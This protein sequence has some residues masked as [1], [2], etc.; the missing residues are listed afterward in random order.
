MRAAAATALALAASGAAALPATAPKYVFFVIV[1]DLGW[2]NV[3]FHRGPNTPFR[4]ETVTPNIDALAAEGAILDRHGV[5][6]QCTP[7][8]SSFLTGRL[9][10]H[11]QVTLANPESHEAGVPYN[12]TTIGEVM[13]KVAGGGGEVGGGASAGGRRLSCRPRRLFLPVRCA[14]HH[15][16]SALPPAQVGKWD[17]GMATHRHTPEGRGFD[18][19]LICECARSGVCAGQYAAR[20]QVGARAPH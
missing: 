6:H 19:S 1:D 17:A 12:M 4:N 7:S 8:R 10:V 9:P 13:K 16:A 20:T 15:R 18:T 5:Y 2:A 3:G 11:V 14:L